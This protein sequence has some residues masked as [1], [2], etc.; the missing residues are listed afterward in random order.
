MHTEAERILEGGKVYKKPFSD[1]W[2]LQLKKRKD[3]VRKYQNTNNALTDGDRYVSMKYK[4][5][6]S[7]VISYLN[8]SS[9]MIHYKSQALS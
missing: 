2:I 1:I 6:Y 4:K 7:A 8:L 5:C 9:A 3:C